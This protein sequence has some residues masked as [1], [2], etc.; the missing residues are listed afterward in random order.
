LAAF[1]LTKSRRFRGEELPSA[2][3][4]FLISTAFKPPETAVLRAPQNLILQSQQ[5]K[6]CDANVSCE[7]APP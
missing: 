5:I 2:A 3:V 1:E 7:S 4:L 6:I